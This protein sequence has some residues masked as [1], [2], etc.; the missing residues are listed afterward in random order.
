MSLVRDVIDRVLFP[1][2]EIHVIPVL[3]GAFS[4]NQRLDRARELGSEIARPDDLAFGPDGA[5]YVSSGD[6]D[7]LALHGIG[8]AERDEFAR[9]PASVGGLA[10]TADGRLLACV[11]G[12]GLSLAIERRRGARMAGN[13]GG[14][15]AGLSHLGDRSQRRNYLRRPKARAR[16]RPTFGS[17]ISCRI[18]RPPDA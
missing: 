13:G 1:N 14:R 18:A 10:W 4:P 5:L 3:D 12:R 6:H 11:S 17:P 2:R 16:T 9:L 7:H 15:A 8:L